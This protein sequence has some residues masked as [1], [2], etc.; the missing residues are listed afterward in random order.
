MHFLNVVALALISVS[1]AVHLGSVEQSKIALT[2]TAEISEQQQYGHTIAQ[3]GQITDA[4]EQDDDDSSPSFNEWAECYIF[5]DLPSECTAKDPNG[6]YKNCY[7]KGEDCGDVSWDL[8]FGE[9][10]D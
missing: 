5:S 8:C 3:V 2:Q 6:F 1:D 10:C 4:G 9:G 7:T